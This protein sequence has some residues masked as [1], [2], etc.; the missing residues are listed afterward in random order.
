MSKS[1]YARENLSHSVNPTATIARCLLGGLLSLFIIMSPCGAT[2]QSPS[3]KSLRSM[4]LVGYQ[5]WFRC[6][7]DGSPA[8]T[9]RHWSKGQPAPETM[10]GDHGLAAGFC[11]RIRLPDGYSLTWSQFLA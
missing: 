9:W 4:V 5:G 1:I 7:G 6:S 10:S 3:G 2:A 8:N 11:G